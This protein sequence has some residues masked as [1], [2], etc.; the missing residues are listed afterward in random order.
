MTAVITKVRLA[1]AHEG[2]AELI[3]SL[4]YDN[5]GESEI[6]LDQATGAHL[7][8]GC[9]ATHMDELVGQG[10]ERVR[11]ALTTSYNGMD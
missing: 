10:W 6:A 5:G 3:V 7:M 8:Q 11:D 4:T 1:A 9:G 2:V